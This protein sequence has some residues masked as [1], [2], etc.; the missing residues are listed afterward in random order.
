MRLS[1]R[2]TL[3][4]GATAGVCA[5]AVTYPLEVIRRKMQLERILAA[6]QIL[7][8]AQRGALAAT[9]RC[10]I[11]MVMLPRSSANNMSDSSK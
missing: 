3:L 6:Q 1:P 4:F 2:A 10:A 11:V 7:T 9:V 5:E 8:T